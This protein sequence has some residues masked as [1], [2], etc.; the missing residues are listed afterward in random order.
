MTEKSPR[1]STRT[2]AAATTKTTATPHHK[3]LA[4]INCFGNDL[5]NKSFTRD[6]VATGRW[7]VDAQNVL[8]NVLNHLDSKMGGEKEVLMSALG[9]CQ[10]VESIAQDEPRIQHLEQMFAVRDELNAQDG[11]LDKTRNL[12][13]AFKFAACEEADHPGIRGSLYWPDLI[14]VVER[15]LPKFDDLE[16]RLRKAVEQVHFEVRTMKAD[17]EL[18]QH[19][20]TS[21]RREALATLADAQA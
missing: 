14:E 16:L 1:V 17:E 8:V 4:E 15:T 18:R 3:R 6:L 19:K 10:T 9:N 5:V 13:L 11:N 12:L 2:K 21:R 7:P 20:E